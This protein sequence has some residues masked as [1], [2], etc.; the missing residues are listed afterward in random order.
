MLTESSSRPEFI[1]FPLGDKTA[2]VTFEDAVSK[3]ELSLQVL[4]AAMAEA[5]Q[6]NQRFAAF[7]ERIDEPA[8]CEIVRAIRRAKDILLHKQE[9]EGTIEFDPD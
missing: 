8:A 5:E 2:Y 9:T 6:W 7:F 1:E 4:E 3:P